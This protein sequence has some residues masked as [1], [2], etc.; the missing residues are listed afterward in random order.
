[1]DK[2]EI[3]KQLKHFRQLAGLT[4]EAL[5]EKVNIHEKQISRIESGLHFPT[6]DNLMKI[7][8]VL[9]VEM[10]DFKSEKNCPTLNKSKEKLIQIINS[11]EDKDIELYLALIQDIQKYLRI[12]PR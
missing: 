11:A 8:K 5:A 3:G 7:L 2:K 6:F 9:N 10:K 4:Q 12:S 1:M